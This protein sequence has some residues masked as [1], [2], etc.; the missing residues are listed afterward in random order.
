MQSIAMSLDDR[1]VAVASGD[2]V[3]LEGRMTAL[4]HAGRDLAIAGGRVWIAR[5]DEVESVALAG[6]EPEKLVL[7]PTAYALAGAGAALAVWSTRGSWIVRGGAMYPLGPARL[8]RTIGESRFLVAEGD[9]CS[10][11]DAAGSG[12][13]TRMRLGMSARVLDA[14]CLLDRSTWLMLVA[15]GGDQELVVMRGNGGVLVR[16]RVGQ[17]HR[18]AGAARKFVVAL[19]TGDGRVIA[20][21][22]R[23]RRVVSADRLAVTA[24]EIAMRRDGDQV[25]GLAW[26]GKTSRLFEKQLVS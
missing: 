12:E 5:N 26:H 23:E 4:A 11:I 14:T 18:I 8:V 2:S 7:A 20:Y 6:G 25:I 22:L 24:C 21:D 9:T 1:H 16:V 19:A 15:R 3:W 17:V 10:I 13:P